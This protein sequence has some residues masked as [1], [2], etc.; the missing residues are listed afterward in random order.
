[1][2]EFSKTI[3]QNVS[4]DK[5]LFC[6]ELRKSINWLSYDEAKNLK[7]WCL[8][9]FGHAYADVIYESFEKS[10]IVVM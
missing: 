8:A 7:I 4:F 2:L 1:M 10:G 5:N 3:L 9:Y 6:K